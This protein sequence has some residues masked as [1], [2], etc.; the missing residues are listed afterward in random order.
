MFNSRKLIALT[1]AAGALLLMAPATS[2]APLFHERF[3]DDSSEVFDNFCGPDENSGLDGVIHTFDVHGV[4]KAGGRGDDQLL[5]FL[6]SVHGT[7]SF[8]NPL[9]G[10]SYNHEFNGVI[11]DYQVTDN[12]D[13]TLT[14]VNGG[15]GIDK[16]WSDDGSLY[17]KD[18]GTT[19][20]AVLI[21]TNGTP[22][23][24]EDD[25]FL[26]D[27]GIVKPSTGQSDTVGRD[28]CEDFYIATS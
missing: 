21:D 12:G 5:Y 11:K 23:D 16:W 15:A 2:A 6:D 19:R 25:V 3:H 13:G 14:I 28:F 26:K 7:E 24:P 1:S 8:T 17:L 22:T 20:F 10:K 9:T 18:A 27:L 4:S